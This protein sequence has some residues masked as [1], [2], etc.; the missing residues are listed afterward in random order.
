MIDIS[1]L[2]DNFLLNHTYVNYTYKLTLACAFLLILSF[3][4]GVF[5]NISMNFE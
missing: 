1:L 2:R 5:P 4:F 3:F